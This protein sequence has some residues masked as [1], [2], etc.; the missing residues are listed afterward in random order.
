M[1]IPCH[2]CDRFRQGEKKIR[3]K[4]LQPIKEDAVEWLMTD[5]EN[6]IKM[7][8]R[9]GNDHIQF[10]IVAKT[11]K[12][13]KMNWQTLELEN[14]LKCTSMCDKPIKFLDTAKKKQQERQWSTLAG[15]W[16]KDHL[17][18]ARTAQLKKQDRRMCQSTQRERTQKNQMVFGTMP[19]CRS[20]Q[21]TESLEARQHGIL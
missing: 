14:R 18:H 19:V 17:S 7:V 5:N 21:P 9:G 4:R 15:S 6:G 1:D 10:D 16:C 20:S 12:G 3:S 2:H 8:R 11:A 13:A